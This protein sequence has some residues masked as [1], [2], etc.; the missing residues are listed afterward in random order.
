MVLF[1]VIGLFFFYKT[2]F[3]AIKKIERVKEPLYK[4]A[5]L[6]LKENAP[7]HETIFHGD[8]D[9]FPQ[10]F[11]YNPDNYY[12]CG[13]DPIFMYAYDPE[14]WL[15]WK[16]INRGE[17]MHPDVVIKT[18]F[19]SRYAFLTKDLRKAVEQF[20][21][22]PNMSIGYEDKHC[23]VFQIHDE[24]VNPATDTLS[25]PSKDSPAGLIAPVT[26]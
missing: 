14:L 16:T 1:L 12:L 8:W 20:R 24:V 22:H 10:L 26:P 4:N 6:W 18:R 19:E 2:Y 25:I 5:A 15:A 17:S 11:Y 21:Q 23:I 13:L 7:D 9:D 3:N